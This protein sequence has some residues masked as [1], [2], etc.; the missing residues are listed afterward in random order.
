MSNNRVTPQDRPR[1]NDAELATLGGVLIDPHWIVRLRDELEL[2]PLDFDCGAGVH[3]WIFEGMVELQEA[4]QPIDLVTLSDLL[5]QKEGDRGK[6]RL[7][8]MGGPAFLSGLINDTPTSIHTLGYG[9][10]VK[11]CAVI[12]N[13]I[14]MC[15]EVVRRA[16]ETGHSHVDVVELIELVEEQVM[17]VSPAVKKTGLKSLK[18]SA[19]NFLDKLEILY[20][21]RQEGLIIGLPTGLIDVD[22]LFGGFQKGDVYTLAA[23]PGMGKT[24]MSLDFAWHWSHKLKRRGVFFSAEMSD[25]QIVQ[26]LIN[27]ITG[28][29]VKRLRVGDIRE[30]YW[31]EKRQE[32]VNEWQELIRAVNDI[33][34]T[35]IIIDDTPEPSIQHIRATARRLYLDGGLDYAIIDYLQLIKAVGR[36]GNREQEVASISKSIKGMAR[37]LNIPVLSLAQLSRAVEGRSDK[38]PILSDLRESGSV[39]QD[40]DAV[41]FIY[42]EGY[43]K[44]DSDF[45]NL[46]ELIVAKYRHDET[47]VI[48]LFFRGQ[49][50]R[51][52]SL[53]K[54]EHQIEYAPIDN[55]SKGGGLDSAKAIKD[56]AQQV[57]TT[58]EFDLSDM[59]D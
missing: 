10:I 39:E 57:Y 13:V 27:K 52:E 42:R 24:A 47:G 19:G 16:F 12:R 34:N 51:F 1:N 9:E 36:H 45:P 3:A 48:E 28:I 55:K 54:K 20:Q 15:S 59:G 49:H 56:V 50:M 14:D 38:R 25:E 33:A 41:L 22:K 40:S 53:V 11:S 32:H 6:S 17:K 21:N 37:E 44:K 2:E 35:E 8:C 7:E 23:R 5:E 4:K 31:N 18:D 46:V 43:Y 58:K 26:R 30:S 29:P